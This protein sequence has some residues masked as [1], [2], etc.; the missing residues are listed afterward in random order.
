MDIAGSILIAGRGE[1][2][3]SWSGW[4]IWGVADF[5]LDLRQAAGEQLGAE[6]NSHD[7]KAKW[8][9]GFVSDF[10][11]HCDRRGSEERAPRRHHDRAGTD[12]GP[13]TFRR[14]CT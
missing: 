6:Q 8:V 2:S 12:C 4:G 7:A 1:G 3:F 10:L 14:G 11:A 9:A 5:R 13:W